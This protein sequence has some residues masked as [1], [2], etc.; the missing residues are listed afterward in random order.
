MTCWVGLDLVNI[1]IQ[2]Y[3]RSG[4]FAPLVFRDL[5]LD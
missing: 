4:D 3:M 5:K 2:R 1:R